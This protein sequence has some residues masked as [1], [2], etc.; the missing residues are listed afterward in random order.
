M[1]ALE[2]LEEQGRIQG[3]HGNIPPSYWKIGGKNLEISNSL[4][5][6]VKLFKDL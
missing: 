1:Y 4:K 2:Y 3:E 6:H 5:R